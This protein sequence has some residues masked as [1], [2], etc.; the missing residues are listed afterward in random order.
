MLYHLLRDSAQRDADRPAVRY[1]DAVLTYGELDR[2]TDALASL[3]CAQGVGRNS[4]VGVYIDKSIE[5]VVALLGILKTGACYV[6]LD[7]MSPPERSVQILSNCA[8]EW[9]VTSAKKRVRLQGFLKEPLPLRHLTILDAENASLREAFRPWTV[10]TREDLPA[11]A[12]PPGA[13]DDP[14]SLAYIL[15]TSGSTGVPKGVMISHRASRAFVDWAQA[16]FGI[17][18]A[19]VVSSHAPFHFDLSILDLYAALKGGA[20]ICLVP[21]GVSVFPKSLA[22]LI[23][24]ERITTWYSVPS[25]LTQLV[26]NGDLATRDLS[27]LR[28]IL[29]AGEVFPS[30]YLRRLMALAPRARY[31]NLYGPTETNVCTCF[32]VAQ[33]PQTHEPV[34]IGADCCGDRGYVVD[35][36][37]KRVPEGE[38]GEL[39]MGGPTLMSGYW[40]DAE[41]T[42]RLLIP[43][44]FEPEVRPL[45][46]RTGDLVRR[47]ADGNYKFH[48]RRDSMVKTRGYRVELGE[49]EAALYHHPEILEAAVVAIPDELITNR[50]EAWVVLRG[51]AGSS[52]QDLKRFCADRVPAYMIPEKIHLARALPKTSTQKVDKKLLAAGEYRE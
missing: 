11:H 28:Q 25:I 49:V 48:G 32:E 50:L 2:R 51:E 18:P 52:E 27:A 9:L 38:L 6:P 26:L 20:T 45:L 24:A 19:D 35:E 31:F 42:A 16:T 21:Q 5:S 17:G 1:K 23:E 13:R 44:P 34:S 22:A 12:A 33:P 37:G 14:E 40:G 41:K 7:P 10:W 8:L 43:N 4:R 15:Y 47:Q 30:A 29:F 3:L 36:A 39:W 46:Y